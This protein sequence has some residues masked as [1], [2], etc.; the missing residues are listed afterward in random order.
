M[1]LS[2]SQ[3]LKSHKNSGEIPQTPSPPACML[4]L[5]LARSPSC[6]Y[7]AMDPP[8]VALPV[9]KVVSWP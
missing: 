1:E 2:Q 6:Q 4:N 3:G 5:H 9:S 7:P 8:P